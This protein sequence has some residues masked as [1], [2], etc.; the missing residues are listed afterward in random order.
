MTFDP[1]S[2]QC[3][4]EDQGCTEKKNAAANPLNCRNMWY[5]DDMANKCKAVACPTDGSAP[6][7]CDTTKADCI[8][9]GSKNVCGV[10][11]SSKY[12]HPYSFECVATG[13]CATGSGSG[14]N[15]LQV[16]IDSDQKFCSKC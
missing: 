11:A 8:N 6:K 16:T 2:G 12:R 3:L 15:H 7:E 5:A 10:C 4:A 9:N 13:T 14:K 1:V